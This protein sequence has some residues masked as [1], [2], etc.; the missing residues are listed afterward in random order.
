MQSKFSV[1]AADRPDKV[2]GAHGYAPS[3][4]QLLASFF[5]AGRKIKAGVDLGQID[6]RSIAA[7]LARAMGVPFT[8]ADLPALPVF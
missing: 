4:P 6:M 1:V 2:G 8:T 7:T 3:N 5:I